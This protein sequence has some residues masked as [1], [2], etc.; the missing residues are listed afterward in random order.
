MRLLGWNWEGGGHG[1]FILS[2]C[3]IFT[4]T[5]VSSLSTHVALT[6]YISDGAS[7]SILAI[8]DFSARCSTS[9][10]SLTLLRYLISYSMLYKPAACNMADMSVIA[11]Q[12][13]NICTGWA[14]LHRRLF[15]RESSHCSPPYWIINHSA[16]SNG[17]NGDWHRPQHIIR[18][19][20]VIA[21]C[22]YVCVSRKS[23]R[24]ALATR[25]N[26]SCGINGALATP[27]I[28]QLLFLIHLRGQLF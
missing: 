22:V 7:G 12:C 25:K 17:C 3:T 27:L 23:T 16:S 6:T 4:T 2:I 24:R 26:E 15:I 19:K 21:M 9:S 8:A 20:N 18:C 1:C 5:T 10:S 28:P 11:E 14:T 13:R